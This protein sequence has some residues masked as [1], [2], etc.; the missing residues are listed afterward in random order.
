MRIEKRYYLEAKK[1]WD[2]LEAETNDDYELQ[3]DADAFFQTCQKNANS[4]RHS[5]DLQ[6]IER[7][8]RL[9]KKA[10]L[11]AECLNLDII[12]EQDETLTGRIT[13]SGPCFVLDSSF[14]DDIRSIFNELLQSAD[15]LF[16]HPV[17]DRV[18]I[19]F[20]F[21]LFAE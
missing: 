2:A 3:I 11:M 8:T 1:E 12:I 16:M 9:Y 18:E 4:F 7:F 10:L 21:Y 19:I 14:I 20:E 6:K 5:P 13:L 17:N 15:Y